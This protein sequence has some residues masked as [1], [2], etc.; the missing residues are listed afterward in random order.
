MADWTLVSEHYRTGKGLLQI[1]WP[2][3]ILG[4]FAL[5]FGIMLEFVPTRPGQE[6]ITRIL[7]IAGMIG[8]V[9]LLSVG[10]WRFLGVPAT[11]RVYDQGLQW[12]HEGRDYQKGWDEV[13]EVYRKEMHVV[14]AGGRPSD[15]N[16]RSELRLVFTDGTEVRFNHVLSDYNQ[17]AGYVQQASAERLLPAARAALD[18]SGAIFGRIHVSRE[19]LTVGHEVTPWAAMNQVWVGNGYLG[20]YDTRGYK[21][22]FPLKDLP[23]YRVLL[24][25][26]EEMRQA[27]RVT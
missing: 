25:L 15:W 11:V 21:R 16:R 27:P 19:G 7:G 18:R 4:G 17:F 5:L 24:A 3:L 9:V 6:T 20:W 8:G 23:N 10:P 14:H 1:S 22:E 2:F 12:R 13:H 26:L